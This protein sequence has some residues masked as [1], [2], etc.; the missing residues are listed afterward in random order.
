[1]KKRR[2]YYQNEPAEGHAFL[3]LPMGDIEEV[4]VII[5]EADRTLV[6]RESAKTGIVPSECL[7]KTLEAAIFAATGLTEAR[8]Q[9]IADGAT[10]RA[11]AVRAHTE[12]PAKTRT[13]VRGA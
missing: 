1:M 2:Q 12:R 4:E 5:P 9:A 8:M 13:I 6:R 3:L 10:P 7:Y 11:C